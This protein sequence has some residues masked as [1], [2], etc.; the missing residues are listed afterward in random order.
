MIGGLMGSPALA[1]WTAVEGARA[2]AGDPL[3]WWRLGERSETASYWSAPTSAPDG[4]RQVEVVTLGSWTRGGTPRLRVL[5]VRL[6]CETG[7]GREQWAGSY[8]LGEAFGGASE[9]WSTPR[10][11]AQRGPGDLRAFACGHGAA[12]AL[13]DLEAVAADA[14]RRLGYAPP[15]DPN[16]PPPPLM[17]PRA[18][19]WE[20]APSPKNELGPQQLVWESGRL[21]VFLMT[22]G[23]VR[24]GG[25]VAGRSM[26]LSGAGQD[27]GQ[28]GYLVRAFRA[29]C[30]ARKIGFAAT[31][32][33]PRTTTA[34]GAGVESG[35]VAPET[36]AQAALLST[37]CGEV[38]PKR[39]LAST[40]ELL[41]Y[42]AAPNEDLTFVAR[43]QKTIEATQMLWSRTPSEKTLAKALPPGTVQAGRNE[44]TFVYCIV[45]KG[46]R[47]QDCKAA[48]WADKALAAAHLALMDEYRPAKSVSGD[49]TLGRRVVSRIAW[50][51]QGGQI[52]PVLVP[53]SQMR[54]AMTP[55]IKDLERAYGSL[56][57]AEATM[58][59]KVAATRLLEQCRAIARV[60]GRPEEITDPASVKPDA[61]PNLKLAGALLQRSL[62]FVPALLTSIGEPTAGRA[63]MIP[64]SWPPVGR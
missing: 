28:Q 32:F 38:Q 52:D 49:D 60:N 36:P 10:F 7:V 35:P 44:Y 30:A 50:T 53:L 19:A 61:A 41:A 12:G 24:D 45:G 25:A 27:E 3:V 42:A 2:E 51:P 5:R 48:E 15:P 34:M 21:S 23:L 47:L 39:T 8:K 22:G 9:P 11:Y 20:N 1:G 31:S 4:E 56:E 37:A 18:P 43:R 59:C 58:Y 17:I 6:D 63:V 57:P 14:A 64:V 16:A 13:P 46:Y 29:D 33:W 62:Y 55:A 26:W 54:W 40:S